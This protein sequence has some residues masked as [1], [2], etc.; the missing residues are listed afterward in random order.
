MRHISEKAACRG[1]TLVELLLATAL[2]GVL[3]AIAVPSYRGAVEHTKMARARSE[4]AMIHMAV[5]ATRGPDF[6]LPESLA[7]VRGVP[8][9]DPWGR[10]YAYYYFDRP[11]A[12][13]GQIRKD[14]NLV[15][16]NSEFD[17]YSVGKDGISRPPLTA[18]PSR[19]DII[20]GR[21]GAFI[22][23]ATKF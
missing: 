19:D 15:P 6:R 9:T 17:L 21:D 3:T 14:R 10:P 11:G 20:V 1:L 8:L 23:L 18:A 2:V 13:R 12:N 22:G 4:L 7:Q 5:L 16:I